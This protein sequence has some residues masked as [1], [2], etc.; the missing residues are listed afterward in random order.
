MPLDKQGVYIVT[1]SDQRLFRCHVEEVGR[2]RQR[3]WI[4]QATNGGRLAYIGPLY[5]PLAHE[6]EL[7]EMVEEWWDMKKQLGQ[8][9]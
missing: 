3:K 1:T 8:A 2:N 4:F 9:D 6:G 7:H 5:Y